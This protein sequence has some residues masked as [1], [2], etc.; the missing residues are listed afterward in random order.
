MTNI[1]LGLLAVSASA[2][3]IA[4]CT[5]DNGEAPNGLAQ[6]APAAATAPARVD[7]FMLVDQDLQ[8]HELHRLAGSK[9]VLIVTQLNGDAEVR[10]RAVR[11]RWRG[12]H[13]V[14]S[15]RRRSCDAWD[16]SVIGETWLVIRK[17]EDGS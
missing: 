1:R 2:A 5:T 15:Y 7:N 9:A 13:G 3:L 14:S 16:R 11:G 10:P 4:G 12:R 6:G 17:S 8:A